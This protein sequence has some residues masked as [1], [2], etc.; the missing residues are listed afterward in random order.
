[1]WFSERSRFLLYGAGF[2][3]WLGGIYALVSQTINR[4]FL[5]GIPL[6]AA[7]GSLFTY[8]MQYILIGALLGVACALPENRWVGVALGGFTAACLIALA[9]L[10]NRWGQASFGMTFVTIFLTFMPIVVLMMPAAFLIR[11]GADAQQVD[12]SR[13]YLWARRYLIPLV[14]TL[15]VVGLGTLSLYGPEVRDAFQYNN[16][17]VRDGLLAGSQNRLPGPLRDVAGF[18]EQSSG[19]YSL[20]W[21]DR[22]DTFF[23][24][25]PAGAEMSQ[26]L[27]ITRFDNG[28]SFA[29][30]YS[31]NRAVPNC[32]NYR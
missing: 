10:A 2:G 19:R 32:T 12:P 7:T 14:L 9:A 13:P 18:L 23:G 16:A 26:F 30:V 15:F 8:V 4:I 29:C 28:F 3:A 6:Q 22:L 11:L 25:R 21:S 31:Q 27:I 24:P 1:M 5:P 17:M 20:E